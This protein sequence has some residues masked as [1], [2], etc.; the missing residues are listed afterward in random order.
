MTRVLVSD[1]SVLID[2]ERGNLLTE[3]F[4]LS[5]QFVVPDL[6]YKHELAAEGGS[7]LIEQGLVVAELDADQ[8][9]LAQTLRSQAPRISLPDAFALALAQTGAYTL[10]TGDQALRELARNNGVE[11]YGVLWVLDQMNQQEVATAAA[12]YN[13]L[14]AI[15]AHPRCRLPKPE[16][17]VRRM[18]WAEAAGIPF[19]G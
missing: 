1:T 5:Y 14:T 10:L 3:T 2:L 17:R 19:D 6:L 7:A 16:I 4:A 12:L 13:G 18:R 11:C 15:A 9:A 8:V